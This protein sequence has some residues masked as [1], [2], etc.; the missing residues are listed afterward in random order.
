MT[1]DR[2]VEAAARVV[3]GGGIVVYPTDT[4]YGLGAGIHHAAAV[5]RLFDVKD[6]APD[7]PLSVAVAD[8][9][10]VTEVAVLTPLARRLLRL[11]PGPVT[12]VLEKLPTVPDAVTGGE[13]TVGVRVPD[14]DVA[15]AL[16]RR[17]GP[18]TATSANRHGAQAP[19][20]LMQARDQL[21]DRVDYYLGSPTPLLGAASTLIDARG[22]SPRILR[23]GAVGE[24]RIRECLVH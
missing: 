22:E 20:T 5:R 21:G 14:H 4:L 6:R 2:D 11:L 13:S 8:P 10:N 18:L 1:D 17:T 3:V 24:D 7:Q 23:R 9:G 16:L 12:F 15:R 19:S